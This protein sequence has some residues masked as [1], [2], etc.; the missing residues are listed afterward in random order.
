MLAYKLDVLLSLVI[1]GAVVPFSLLD[2]YSTPRATNF[3]ANVTVPDKDVLFQAGSDEVVS[4]ILP[5]YDLDDTLLGFTYPSCQG[6][7]LYPAMRL[8]DAESLNW[9]IATKSSI[10]LSWYKIKARKIVDSIITEYDIPDDNKPLLALPVVPIVS[11]FK[12]SASSGSLVH[13]V[14]LFNMLTNRVLYVDSTE[15]T[16]SFLQYALMTVS[17]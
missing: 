12:A 1:Q 11:G 16:I 2:W 13:T 14:I 7:C 3:C 8:T 17:S 4:P 6:L 15:F 9:S 10:L 5:V